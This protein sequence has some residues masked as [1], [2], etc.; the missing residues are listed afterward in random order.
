M[1]P[2]DF[3]ALELPA[4]TKLAATGVG[5][6]QHDRWQ[7]VLVT[8]TDPAVRIGLSRVE[9]MQLIVQLHSLINLPVFARQRN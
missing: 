7:V 8:D 1:R 6:D 9:V 5:P 4:T 3:K 2:P